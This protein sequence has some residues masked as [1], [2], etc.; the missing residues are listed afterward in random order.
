MTA[1]EGEVTTPMTRGNQG[2]GRLRNSR[3]ALRRRAACGAFQHRHQRARAR[4]FDLVDDELIFRLARE[5]GQ[6]A[7]GDDLY[8]F[9]RPGRE[10]RWPAPSTTPR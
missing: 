4:G 6:P 2:N 5:S 1:P 8:A 10:A 3:T 9:F 7:G